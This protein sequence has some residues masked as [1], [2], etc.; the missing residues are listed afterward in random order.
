MARIADVDRKT[1]ETHI[2]LSLN[3]DGEGAWQGDTGVGFLNHMLELFA[4]H[5]HFDLNVAASGDIQVDD[6]HTTEDVGICLGRAF[7]QALGDRAGIRRFGDF[8][9]P[10]EDALAQVAVDLGG[11]SHFVYNVQFPTEKVGS[12]D[13]ALVEEFLGALVANARMNLHVNV[14]YGKNA[15]HIAEAIFK[16]TARALDLA[17]ARDPRTRGVPSTKGV[18]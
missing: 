17:V 4:R 16:A 12:F 9:L 7:D 5:G 10:M 18:V 2:R 3:L 11:R 8:A 6:H 13:T 1:G 14:P 15:H